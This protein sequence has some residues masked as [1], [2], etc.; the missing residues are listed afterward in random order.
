MKNIKK[1]DLFYGWCDRVI[2]PRHYRA[3]G[4][5]DEVGG[6]CNECLQLMGY[7]VIEFRKEKSPRSK[8]NIS[9]PIKLKPE[10]KKKTTRGMAIYKYQKPFKAS[11]KQK[12]ASKE[13]VQ[14]RIKLELETGFYT[15]DDLL[16]KLNGYT[17]SVT[18]LAH[19]L[20]QMKR[21]GKIKGRGINQSGKLIYYLPN[22]EKEFN[23]YIGIGFKESI[24]QILRDR[25]SPITI[26]ELATIMHRP[27]QTVRVW[28]QDLEVEGKIK[29]EVVPIKGK[30][31]TYKMISLNKE[32]AKATPYA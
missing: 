18:R 4:Y 17:E 7:K 13:L 19:V 22:R 31:G 25:R 10:H 15:A 11:K 14:C 6:I 29:C 8:T 16:V 24:E 26:A 2:K 3:M 12:G 32:S 28:I 30:K 5:K 9:K 21:S 23:E 20:W 27:A 1:T